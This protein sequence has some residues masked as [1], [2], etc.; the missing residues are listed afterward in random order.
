MKKSLLICCFLI[1]FSCSKKIPKNEKPTFLIGN[2]L[3]T[4]DK[5]G[6]IT[7]ENWQKNFTGLGYTLQEKDT[8]FKEVM[9]I[10]TLSDTLFLKIESVN[11]TPTLFKFTSKTDTSFVC[12]N[13]QNEF[14]KK[15]IYFKD[16]NK[17]KAVVSNNEFSINFVFEKVK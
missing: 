4:N 10:V 11:E 3:R 7:Y 1:L 16:K 17:L 9:S 15:I 8:A 12:E 14:P 5:K 13:T 6:S 2:W